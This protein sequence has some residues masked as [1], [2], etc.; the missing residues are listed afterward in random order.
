MNYFTDLFSPE[1]YQAF[2]NSNREVSGFRLTQRASANRVQIG[3]RF[4]C[5]VTRLSRWVGILEALS[6]VYE[7]HTPI[8][9]EK[10]DPFVV[11]FRVKPIAWLPIYRAIP[12][13]ENEIWNSL[14]FTKG[15]DKSSSTWTGKVRRSLNEIDGADAKL[16][17]GKLIAQLD[18]E[19][20]YPLEEHDN[21]KLVT[22]KVRT[23][24]KVISVTVPDDIQVEAEVGAEVAT[25][26]RESIKIQAL[27][28][29]IGAKMGFKIWLPKSD[30]GSVFE[31]WK[32]ESFPVL[33][34]LPLNYD[35]TT[36][37]TI[38]RIDVL[39]LKGRYI[40]RAFEVEHSTSI[41]S[42]MLRMA[43]LLA[44]VPNMDINLHIVAP[45]SR[46][47][48]VFQE[49]RRPVF[50]LLDKGPLSESCTFIS[51]D[52]LRELG[53]L[54]HIAYTSDGILEEYAE[55]VE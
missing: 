53:A 27:I 19:R 38:E 32:P 39:W 6:L 26:I 24:D 49:L 4:V 54:K 34:I 14:S 10:D 42:G 44:L 30:R 8:F 2:S 50:S 31:E 45:Y 29:S 13:H 9:L 43:D 36:L 21:K 3:D 33:D 35:D 52:S 18:S 37:K 22:H 12:I 11:R 7:D 28:A 23:A 47:E 55:S 1:T 40:V 41:Y 16:L 25:E 46:R 20:T 5:Y 48:K 15:Y 51:Y 17:E